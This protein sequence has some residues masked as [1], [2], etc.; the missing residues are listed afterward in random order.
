MAHGYKRHSILS[1][2]G[3]IDSTYGPVTTQQRL[4]ELEI[5]VNTAPTSAATLY[6]YRDSG[7]GAEFDTLIYSIN[8][9]AA[10]TTDVFNVALGVP[11]LEG[12][13]LRVTYTNP[14]A[15]TIGVLLH[16]R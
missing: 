13:G 4:E 5:H 14:D 1:V 16:L 10:S 15:R 6:L 3:A 2:G 12:D 11:L 7:L 8:L 9:Q